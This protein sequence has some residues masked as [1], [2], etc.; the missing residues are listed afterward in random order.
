MTTKL[1]A[2]TANIVIQLLIWF[3]K[4]GAGAGNPSTS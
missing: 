1:S 2:N 3:I 4:L